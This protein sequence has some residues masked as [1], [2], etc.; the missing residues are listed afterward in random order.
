MSPDWMQIL[1]KHGET[2]QHLHAKV[3][4]ILASESLTVDQ[5]LLL[6]RIVEKGAR[7]A[8]GLASQMLEAGVGPS[9]I[10]AAEALQEIYKVLLAAIDAKVQALRRRKIVLVSDT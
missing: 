10:E 6:G 9:Y 8:D 2:V 5:V 1:Q 3:Q 7:Y 4:I